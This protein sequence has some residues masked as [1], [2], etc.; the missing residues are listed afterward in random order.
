M[1]LG[2]IGI[3]TEFAIAVL[4]A[5]IQLQVQRALFI[6]VALLT[7]GYIERADRGTQHNI[8]GQHRPRDAEFAQ[9]KL[10]GQAFAPVQREIE[11]NARMQRRIGDQRSIHIHTNAI[12][13]CIKIDF[14]IVDIDVVLRSHAQ[15]QTRLIDAELE[16]RIFVDQVVNAF[17]V[18]LNR[19]IQ[20]D[21]LSILRN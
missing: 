4:Q 13:L 12:Q 2:R 19:T 18:F 14:Q 5:D 11:I 1:I 21:G 17:E 8:I 6:R 7:N 20:R 15:L 16:C 9:I 3:E 10:G